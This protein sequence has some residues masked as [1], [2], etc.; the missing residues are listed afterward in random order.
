MI[1][2]LSRRS[3]LARLASG[4]GSSVADRAPERRAI[5]VV[6]D[7]VTAEGLTPI[8][9]LN[10]VLLDASRTDRWVALRA[11]LGP[12]RLERPLILCQGGRPGAPVLIQGVDARLKPLTARVVGSRAAVFSRGAA[13]GSEAF[14]LLEGASHLTFKRIAFERVGN[15]CFRFAGLVSDILIEDCSAENVFRFIENFSAESD[16]SI[17]ALRIRNVRARGLERS[18]IRLGYSSSNIEVVDCFA[19]GAY[20]S[21]SAFAVGCALEGTV[22]EVVYCRVSMKRFGQLPPGVGPHD[23]WN[24]D[25]FS[26]EVGNSKI[27]YINCRASGCADGGF[28]DKGSSITHLRTIASGN[29]RNYRLWGRGHIVQDATSVAPKSLGG[30]GDACHFWFGQAQASES[31]TARLIR[32]RITDGKEGATSYHLTGRTQMSLEHPRESRSRLGVRFDLSSEAS[33]VQDTG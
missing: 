8:S 11:D 28:D 2:N 15:G 5:T 7:G 30:T 10:G 21:D 26:S 31:C 9:R 25:G 20:N 24:G 12:Y 16:A 4:A 3:V 27:T 6:P 13:D 18:F 17:H 32:P 19:D 14:R 29:K 1:S 33:V 23:Y 22:S